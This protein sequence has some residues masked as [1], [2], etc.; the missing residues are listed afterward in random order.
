MYFC[1][2]WEWAGIC[3]LNFALFLLRQAKSVPPPSSNI[4]LQPETTSTRSDALIQFTQEVQELLDDGKFVYSF[5]K[6]N[7]LQDGRSLSLKPKI[8]PELYEAHDLA[9]LPL[10]MVWQNFLNVMQHNENINKEKGDPNYLPAK[11][12][13]AINKLRKYLEKF[14]DALNRRSFTDCF[15]IAVKMHTEI[16]SSSEINMFVGTNRTTS[17]AVHTLVLKITSTMFNA[18]EQIESGHKE[19]FWNGQETSGL[20]D[21]PPSVPPE[22]SE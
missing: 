19:L 13:S 2:V 20:L 11:N 9:V 1:A 15:E 8:H 16:K 5:V 17:L 10:G 3:D 18:L 21:L 14:Q 12:S 22:L 4:M 7:Q 6:E